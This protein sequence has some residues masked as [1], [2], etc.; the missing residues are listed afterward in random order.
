[1]VFDD[2]YTKERHL[3]LLPIKTTMGVV[4][5]NAVKH[6]FVKESAPLEKLMLVTTDGLHAGFIALC[7][8]EP[9]F[10]K[11]NYLCLFH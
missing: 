5:Y 8:G 7:K 11:F 2:F 4:I 10:P 6:F 1:M 3:I 9:D